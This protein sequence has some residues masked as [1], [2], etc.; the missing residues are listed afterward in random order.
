[1]MVT[2][3]AIGVAG[4][5]ALTRVTAGFL[6]GVRPTDGTTFG[7]GVLLFLAVAFA[8]TFAPARRAARVDPAV[9]FRSE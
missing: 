5:L 4:S 9:A 3:I 6:H 8:S 1:M 2:G 7:A